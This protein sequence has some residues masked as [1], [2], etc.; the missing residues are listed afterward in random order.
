[1]SWVYTLEIWL[2]IPLLAVPVQLRLI[3]FRLLLLI[4]VYVS[5]ELPIIR[6]TSCCNVVLLLFC[7]I[8]SNSSRLCELPCCCHARIWFRFCGLL[9]FFSISV[10][11]SRMFLQELELVAL[12]S[13]IT[14]VKPPTIRGR[15]CD[16]VLPGPDY[17]APQKQW[18]TRPEERQKRRNSEKP[19]S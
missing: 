16:Y 13:R 17:S 10:S 3:F 8:A 5:A 9:D 7:V 15:N 6:C 12:P 11:L 1:M 14:E 4:S 18:Q 2:Y 19:L